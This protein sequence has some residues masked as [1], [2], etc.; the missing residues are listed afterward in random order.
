MC[1]LNEYKEVDVRKQQLKSEV[2]RLKEEINSLKKTWLREI[3]RRLKQDFLVAEEFF[4]ILPLGIISRSEFENQ[5]EHVRQGRLREEAQTRKQQLKSEVMRLKEEVNFLKK[6]WLREIDRKLKQ[7]FLAVEEFF[8]SL[9]LKIISREE[10]QTQ[11]LAFVREWFQEK[12]ARLGMKDKPAPDEEQL[13]A[14]A[15]VNGNVQVVA[16]AGS[17]KTATLINRAFFLLQHCWVDPDH[18]MLL[19]FNKK[20]ANEMAW[21]LAGM[22]IPAAEAEIKEVLD[23]RW[24][25]KK[26]NP[27]S[28]KSDFEEESI[29]EVVKRH[30][31]RLPHIMTFHA[32]AHALVRPKEEILYDDETAEQQKQSRE[33]QCLIE[34][35]L[36]HRPDYIDR[37]RRLMLARFKEDWEKIERGHYFDSRDDFLRY[38]R[39]FSSFTLGG[40]T[41]NSFGEQQIANFLFEHGGLP[42]R[43]KEGETCPA[44]Y[45]QYKWGNRFELNGH[46]Y[47]PDF[48][49]FLPNKYLVIIECFGMEGD[50]NYDVETAGKIEFWEKNAERHKVVSFL[51]LYREDI[52]SGKFS[53]KLESLLRGKG[54]CCDLLAEEEIWRRARKR[55]IDSYTT[56][57][58]GFINRC[59]CMGLSYKE[60]E[61]KIQTHRWVK[62]EEYWFLELAQEFYGAYVQRLPEKN[63]DDFSG[64]VLRAAGQVLQGDCGFARKG[65]QGDTRALRWLCVDE[66]QD[67][68]ELFYRLLAA[69]CKAAPKL[70]LFCVG[71]D[72]QAING[73]AGADLRFFENFKSYFGAFEKLYLSTNY[74]SVSSV[75]RAGNALMKNSGKPARA[76]NGSP[77]GVVY[78][79]DAADFRPTPFEEDY[80]KSVRQKMMVTRIVRRASQENKPVV[81]LNRKRIDN[82]NYLKDIRECLPL[83][84]QEIVS[85]STAHRY[86]GLEKP[87]VII[88]DA[89]DK[90]YPLIHPNWI[91]LRVLGESAESIVAAERRLFYVALTRASE[92]LMI[93]TDRQKRSPFLNDIEAVTKPIEW[94]DYPAIH[95]RSGQWR[96]EIKNQNRY[97]CGGTFEIKDQ[98]KRW[99]YKW[100]ASEKCW[101]KNCPADDS[102]LSLIGEEGWIKA[103]DG[104]E[105]RVVDADGKTVGVLDVNDGKLMDSKTDGYRRRQIEV[106]MDDI[107]F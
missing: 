65:R 42:Y 82:N 56:A 91:F 99:G 60:L 1:K 44:F 48:T 107:N 55:A 18:M 24:K 26:E 21:R 101:W 51:P 57:T 80:Y 90:S 97:G 27:D 54:V 50:A 83:D 66:F 63:F 103:A 13:A 45:Y 30:H 59:R 22:R 49:I 77:E 86:K 9:P 29:Y 96:I 87:I 31:V 46:P 10:F 84:K 6:T 40:D 15:A 79:A 8:S 41:V 93:L 92:K 37:V 53:G 25:E 34:E 70:S 33:V 100:D 72:W 58:V 61:E 20:A 36:E 88:L 52:A 95:G 85:A 11:K 4:S 78:L 94:S 5:C 43:E 17:G 102:P 81:L 62:K 14:I 3:D 19:V 47:R 67:F 7:D 98:L 2:I 32:L 23:R 16:R 38:R 89:L 75:V 71:D 39:S 64:L 68:N 74:R 105:I 106:D 12:F 28:R 76:R 35:Y 104:V 69:I 73:F